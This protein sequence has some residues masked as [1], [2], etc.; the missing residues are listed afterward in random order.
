VTL[1]E[2]TALRL[3]P[4]FITMAARAAGKSIHETGQHTAPLQQSK[5]LGRVD[6]ESRGS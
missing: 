4:R 5:S 2:I 6:S 3:C 1:N